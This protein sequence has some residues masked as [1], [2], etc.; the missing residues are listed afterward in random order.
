M[1]R[2]AMAF[3]ALQ[4]PAPAYDSAR[5]Y[6]TLAFMFVVVGGAVAFVRVRYP[7]RLI[8]DIAWTLGLFLLVI[9]T[10][11]YTV[12][13][14]G[15]QF[16]EVIV[17]W[18][19]SF[20]AIAWFVS[21]LNTIMSR[22]LDLLEQLAAAVRRGDWAQLLD[23]DRSALGRADIGAALHGVG[24]LIGETRKTTGEVLGASANVARI[25]STVA[26]G[27]QRVTTS[28]AGVT[29]GV[30]RSLDAARQIKQVASQLD[31]AVGATHASARE[32]R[33]ISAKVETS[34]QLGVTR[35]TDAM[36]AVTELAELARE[37]VS[38][39]DNLRTASA[40]I[41][42]VTTVV[43]DIGRQTNLLALNASIEA[44]RAGEAGRGFAVVAEEVGKLA[45]QSGGSVG[46]IEVL[47]REM[48]ERLEDASERVRRVEHAVGRGEQVM[49]DAL[50]VFQSIEQD[51]R[52][53]L[54][55]A[56]A[57]LRAAE[58][59]DAL[60]REVTQASDLV[61]EAASASSAATDD[62][63][64]ATQHQ[65]TLTEQLRETAYALERSAGSLGE[66]VSRFGTGGGG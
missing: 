56:D 14:R 50:G 34:A 55:L 21:R 60:A 41:A 30:A 57:V 48:T 62:V 4:E 16:G 64:R 26:D 11:V 1:I 42:D 63:A 43:G 45:M 25:G 52:R 66:V 10:I 33:E 19:L 37:L 65:R 47:V 6:A 12:A 27:A 32:T 7:R 58:R 53:T 17:A 54:T 39:M 49:R 9:G 35:A 28:L 3:A 36:T 46:R 59:Q 18:V 38:R 51:A 44:A 2:V 40:A 5:L 24:T 13:F 31:E 8:A 15:L 20:V 23:G 22:P 61:A 29:G